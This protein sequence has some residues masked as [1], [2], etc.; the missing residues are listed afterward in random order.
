MVNEKQPNT[1]GQGN[2]DNLR[3]TRSSEK[4]EA[5]KQLKNEGIK[6]NTKNS[7]KELKKYLGSG[8]TLN[9]R[10]TLKGQSGDRQSLMLGNV[11]KKFNDNLLVF[12]KKYLLEFDTLVKSGLSWDELMRRL[13]IL[14]ARHKKESVGY[15]QAVKYAFMAL[16]GSDRK[17]EKKD[18]AMFNSII[19]NITEAYSKDNDFRKILV[20][21]QQE[22]IQKKDWDVICE[23]LAQYKFQKDVSS[24]RDE[25]RFNINGMLISLMTP[26]QRYQMVLEFSKRSMGQQAEFLAKS[27]TMANVLNTR[28]Y[29]ALMKEFQG[30]NYEL[31]VAD[32][33]EIKKSQAQ[34]RRI[35]EGVAKKMGSPMLIN[36]AERVLNRSSLFATLITGIGFLGMASNYMTHFNAAKGAGKFLAG[37]KS[38]YFMASLGITAYGVHRLGKGMTAGEHGVGMLSKYMPV[39]KRLNNPFGVGKAAEQ[40][41]GYFGELVDIT[42]NHS[43]L[44]RWLLTQNGFNDLNGFYRKKNY[45]VAKLNASVFEPESMEQGKKQSL[46][47]EFI[48]YQESRGNKVGAK[49]IK[50]AIDQYGKKAM[51]TYIVRLIVIGQSIGIPTSNS[52]NRTTVPTQKYKFVDLL[53]HRQGVKSLPKTG[54][55]T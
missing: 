20:N 40:K 52:F 50:Q 49:M 45:D 29:E 23:Y 37:L 54:K 51:Q 25:I 21:I 39:P 19:D 31:S 43:I 26:N 11:L 6:E 14:S 55:T 48:E 33:S 35:E 1:P 8:S 18:F 46:L 38:P 12:E 34:M 3:A 28:Q 9:A 36:G 47:D 2:A 41:D 32:E 5:L 30:N 7:L 24:D 15:M 16:A 27:L 44:E 10:D 4:N 17:L 22:K 42:K 53:R 13:Q